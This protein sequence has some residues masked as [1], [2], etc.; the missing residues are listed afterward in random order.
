MVRGAVRAA[1]VADRFY[2]SQRN[3]L[4]QLV[5]TLAPKPAREEHEKERVHAVLVPHAGYAFSGRVA[6][7]VFSRIR[8]P[9]VAAILCFNHRGHG[10]TFALW[11]GTAWETPLGS[12][13]IEEALARRLRDEFPRLELDGRAHEGEHSG[14][15][16]VPFL[17]YF[18]PDIRILPV[19]LN[20]WTDERGVD[21]LKEFGAALARAVA[22]LGTETLVVASS[23]LNHY[24]RE[25]TT[26]AKDEVAINAM[27][28]LDPDVL[29]NAVAREGVSMCG[30][31]PAAAAMAYTR[32]RGGEGGRLILHA[33]SGDASGDRERV[34]GYAGI[35]FE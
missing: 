22:S 17:Q 29:R 9:S 5:D 20:A 28:T 3:R 26:Y 18:R 10:A 33:T 32:A 11:P 19:S 4:L 25:D 31:A 23:D 12:A 27:L 15:V 7:A 34:V 13:P 24:E 8:I 30:F 14:E 2:P 21:A 35:V 6:A 1:A 16:Q